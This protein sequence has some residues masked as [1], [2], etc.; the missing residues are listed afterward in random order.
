ME[1]HLCA[2]NGTMM[3]PVLHVVLAYG[4]THGLDYG[5]TE[6]FKSMRAVFG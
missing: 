4:D 5:M 1:R 3:R 2:S 6:V